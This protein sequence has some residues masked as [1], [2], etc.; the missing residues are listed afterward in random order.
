MITQQYHLY[1]AEM[2]T[3]NIQIALEESFVRATKTHILI[4]KEGE[5]PG[6]YKEIGKENIYLLPDDDLKW[7]CDVNLE[8]MKQFIADHEE[9][10]RKAEE[11]FVKDFET[12]LEAEKQKLS[13]QERDTV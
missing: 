5:C 2:T 1:V 3:K 7:L 8:L 11:K 6:G 12:E 4:Y 9:E 13:E 10:R